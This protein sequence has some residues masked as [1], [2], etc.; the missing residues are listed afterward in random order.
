MKRNTCCDPFKGYPEPR[1]PKLVR[2]TVWLLI[3][4]L[5]AVLMLASVE[6]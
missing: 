2:F 5:L 4:V 6:G 3:A 1:L